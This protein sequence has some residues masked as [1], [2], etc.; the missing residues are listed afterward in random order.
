[1]TTTL[2]RVLEVIVSTLV[3]SA[4]TASIRLV[5]C[6]SMRSALAPGQMHTAAATRMGIDGSLALGIHW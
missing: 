1:M 6:C 3:F 2:D 4:I 5:T